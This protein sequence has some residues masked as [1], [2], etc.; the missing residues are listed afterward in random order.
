MPLKSKALS[1]P[2]CRNKIAENKETEIWRNFNNV[3]SNIIFVEGLSLIQS[4]EINDF[5]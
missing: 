4:Y 5:E 3:W 2:L 1:S